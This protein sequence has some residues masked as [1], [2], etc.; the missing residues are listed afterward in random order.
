M[1]SPEAT[2]YELRPN[3]HLA[4]GVPNP[5]RYADLAAAEEAGRALRERMPDFRFV[6]IVKID[7]RGRD[8]AETP[9]ARL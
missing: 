3:G 9:I 2:W 7:F 4:I 1:S 5:K 6:E 8:R